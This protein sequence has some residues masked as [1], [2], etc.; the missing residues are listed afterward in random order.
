MP[1]ILIRKKYTSIS[2]GLGKN[3]TKKERKFIIERSAS[4]Y[5]RQ[6]S[7]LPF[8]ANFFRNPAE[9]APTVVYLGLDG[10][11]EDVREV[12]VVSHIDRR[13]EP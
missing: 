7:S 6:P 10:L 4:V 2:L 13:G 11:V 8:V 9:F 3:L 1:L 5:V 12:L